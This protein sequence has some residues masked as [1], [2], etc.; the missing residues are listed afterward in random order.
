MNATNRNFA[1]H[2]RAFR[3]ACDAAGVKPTRRQASRFRM[4]R[5]RAYVIHKDA[6]SR[7][8]NDSASV[9]FGDPPGGEG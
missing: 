4:G 6:D 1:E 5:G 3:D 7:L 9:D 8:T 2:D